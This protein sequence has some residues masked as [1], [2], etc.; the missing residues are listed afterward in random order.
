MRLNKKKSPGFSLQDKDGVVHKLNEVNSDFIILYFYPKDNTP[1]CT[2]EAREF[3][4]DI[5]KF[6]R[7]NATIIG[8]S[9][10]DRESKTKFC[11]KNKLKILLLSDTDFKISKK[12]GVYTKKK[13]L[14][15]TY[16]GIE[17]TTFILN[18]DKKIITTFKKVNPLGH[19][20]K[21]LEYIKKFKSQYGKNNI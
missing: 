9:G 18:K 15:R 16:M 12:F 19:S 20:K 10:G 1:G 21:V 5:D 2:L 17:R 11:E 13:F 4:R 14:G 7:I 6:N 3:N 8:I